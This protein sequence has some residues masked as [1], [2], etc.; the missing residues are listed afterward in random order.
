MGETRSYFIR[1]YLWTQVLR[2]IS[3]KLF[4]KDKFLGTPSKEFLAVLTNNTSIIVFNMT[5]TLTWPMP[6][7]SLEFQPIAQNS[8]FFSVHCVQTD[9]PKVFFCVSSVFL[10]CI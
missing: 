7:N 4:T 2:E 5:M 3:W 10:W 9:A 1:K 6:E 8:Y